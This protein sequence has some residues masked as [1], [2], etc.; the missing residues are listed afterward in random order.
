MEEGQD[1]ERIR[2]IAEEFDNVVSNRD[3]ELAL[4]FFADKCTIEMLGLELNGKEGARKWLKWLFSTFEE[5][6]FEPV[7]I[8][9]ES[10]TFFEEFILIGKLKNGTVIRSKQSE[11]LIYKDYKIT[12]LRLYFDRLDFAEVIGTGPIRRK[13]LKMLKNASLKDLK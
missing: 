1:P 8:M 2:K 13:I 4:S 5:I 11:V 7:T 12:D 6:S 9:I 10:S 3:I